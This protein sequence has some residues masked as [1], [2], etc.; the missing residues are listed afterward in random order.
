VWFSL[1]PS[2]GIGPLIQEASEMT[3]LT[4]WWLV[5]LTVAAVSTHEGIIALVGGGLSLVCQLIAAIRYYRGT[6]IR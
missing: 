3:E 2:N 5:F 4:Y 6:L 1:S